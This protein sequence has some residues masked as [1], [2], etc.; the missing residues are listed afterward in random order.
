MKFKKLLGTLCFAFTTGLLFAQ[1]IHFS[2]YGMSPLTLNPALTGVIG[3]EMRATANYRN[4]WA[5]ILRSNAFTTYT[6]SFD[7]RLPVGRYDYVGLGGMF[8]GDRVGS[9]AFSTYQGALSIS[10]L[11]R[12]GGYRSNESYLVAGAQ[13]GV[14]QRDL[15]T[16]ALIYGSQWDGR[17][18][19]IDPNNPTDPIN[20][21]P[22]FNPNF[23]YMDM[24]AGL[25]YFTALDR[26]GKSN[27]YIGLAFHHL[28]TPNIAFNR[29]DEIPMYSKF[30]AHAGGEFMLNDRFGITP[31]VLFM[32]QGPSFMTVL[33]TYFK[34]KLGT[35]KSLKQAFY[36]GGFSRL[37]NHF[38]DALT[39]D[40]AVIAAK[41]DTG[42]FAFGL[43]YD[44]NL[45]QLKTA[46]SGNGS[47]ELALQYK[48]CKNKKRKM[49]CPEF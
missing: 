27:F 20:G 35:G 26:Q 8:T 43:S 46:T 4:Q 17:T 13:I 31:S 16:S 15:N 33:G 14:T 11:K 19:N 47:F 40:A 30:S 41:F 12:L 10:Y 49:S 3:C 21:N 18:S 2:Q 29:R 9:A 25:F 39:N 28:N 22:S 6:A 48:L 42:P 24:N 32:K 37:S 36:L 7:G 34:F 1:D 5:S 23:I 38:Q 44:L 45:S